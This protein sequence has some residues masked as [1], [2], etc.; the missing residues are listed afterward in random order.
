M[1][2]FPVEF[3]EVWKSRGPHPDYQVLVK[4]SIVTEVGLVL[5]KAQISVFQS[6]GLSRLAF[7]NGNK[8][9]PDEDE[10]W[11]DSASGQYWLPGREL[12]LFEFRVF[13]LI[14]LLRP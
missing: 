7:S 13:W 10:C 2:N 5:S 4:K 8:S 14:G 9:D 12:L 1:V 3:P 6:L 11:E